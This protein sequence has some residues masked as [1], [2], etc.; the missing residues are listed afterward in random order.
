MPASNVIEKRFMCI[1]ALQSHPEIPI[2]VT[3]TP[4]SCRALPLPTLCASLQAH[5]VA[6]S[7]YNRGTCLHVLD[8]ATGSLSANPTVCLQC[9]W[10]RGLLSRYSINHSLMR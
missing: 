5:P 9:W 2:M 8:G 4:R 10:A 7:L 3:C 6:I 1:A